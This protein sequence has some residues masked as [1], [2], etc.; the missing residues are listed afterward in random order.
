MMTHVYRETL[1]LAEIRLMQAEECRVGY[2][3][4]AFKSDAADLLRKAGR[5]DL[6][7]RLDEDAWGGD[8]PAVLDAIREAQAKDG[9]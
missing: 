6:A 2:I 3:G 7:D 8:T 5:G 4:D 9:E 1:R